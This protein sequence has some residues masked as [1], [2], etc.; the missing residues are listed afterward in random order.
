MKPASPAA[1][2]IA[3]YPALCEVARAHGY[4]LATHGSIGRDF[5]LIAAPWT[6]EAVDALTL[7][8]ALKAATGTVTHASHADEYFPDCAPTAKPHGRLAYSLH[9][10]DRGGDGPYLDV[11]VLPR[12]VPS[13]PPLPASVARSVSGL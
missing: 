6:A 1:A 8:K 4:A 3:L 2:Y 9:C 10:T 12:S 7:I 5:D 11:S 13:V